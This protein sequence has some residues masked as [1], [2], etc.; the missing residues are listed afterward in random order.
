MYVT[1]VQVLLQLDHM[2]YHQAMLKKDIMMIWEDWMHGRTIFVS[3][4]WLGWT[5]ADPQDA[6]FRTLKRVLQRLMTGEIPSVELDFLAQMAVPNI[7]V[8]RIPARDIAAKLRD[9]VA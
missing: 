8:T 3:H 5:H 1:N 7:K 6:Q 4:E 9:T 2:Y